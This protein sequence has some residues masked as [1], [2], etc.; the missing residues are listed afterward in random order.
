MTSSIFK[1]SLTG[2]IFLFFNLILLAQ[3]SPW[4]TGIVNDINLGILEDNSVIFPSN[5]GYGNDQNFFPDLINA[6][7]S[8]RVGKL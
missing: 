7:T 6:F 1:R 8:S 2:I 4:G 5:S 3:T